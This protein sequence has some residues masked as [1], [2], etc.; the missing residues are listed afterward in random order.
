M[1]IYKTS[2]GRQAIRAF[3]TE[4][5]ERWPLEHERREIATSCGSTHVVSAGSGPPL[6]LLAGTNFCSSNWLGLIATLSA[7]HRVHAVD[8]PGQPGLSA[9]D[10]PRRAGT[11][12]GHWLTQVLTTIAPTGATVVGHSLGARVALDAALTG[13]TIEKLH[14]VD[15]AGVMWLSVTPRIMRP[16]I[17]WLLQPDTETSTGILRMMMAPDG[18]PP[19]DLVDWMAL[20]GQHVR[21]SLAPTPLPNRALTAIRST[22]TSVLSGQHDA[23]LSPARLTRATSRKLPNAELRIVPHAGHLLPHEQPDAL[24][25]AIT[26]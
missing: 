25:D 1:G 17:P 6:V 10:R 2:D 4:R 18:T 20:V 15:P 22:P 14:L 24:V 11:A 7:T 26:A 12:Y 5:L 8:L 9:A 16:T 23:F 19:R 13:A 21:T 3:A